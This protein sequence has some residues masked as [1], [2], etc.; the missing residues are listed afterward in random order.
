[1]DAYIEKSLHILELPAVLS[2]LADFAVTPTAKENAVKL[3]PLQNPREIRRLLD[4]VS[5]ACRL[6]IKKGNPSFYGV[7]DI[8]GAV[9]R[10]ER[11][12]I[13]TARELLDIATLLR[14]SRGLR[15]YGELRR[16]R[17]NPG[18]NRESSGVNRES[19]GVNREN[20]GVNR[21]NLGKNRENWDQKT[22]NLNEKWQTFKGKNPT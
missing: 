16:N 7:K 9:A 12:G 18:V 5:E 11:G 19:S 17:E 15:D 13:L 3:M 6:I 20:P 4:E 1:M 2:K 8:R 10:S 21:E 22:A 14:V